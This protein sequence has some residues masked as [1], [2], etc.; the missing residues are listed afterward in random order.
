MLKSWI[1]TSGFCAFFF[2]KTHCPLHDSPE[3]NYSTTETCF[4]SHHHQ[5][6]TNSG[7]ECKLVLFYRFL[8][9]GTQSGFVEGSKESLLC[10]VVLHCCLLG[11]VVAAGPHCSDT[12]GG[13]ELRD[14]DRSQTDNKIL[15]CKSHEC[16][17]EDAYLGYFS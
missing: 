12:Q 2:P 6:S 15:S 10:A 7:G 16:K 5:P 13:R 4:L 3:Q 9:P 1:L 11:L 8:H 14:T 17:K